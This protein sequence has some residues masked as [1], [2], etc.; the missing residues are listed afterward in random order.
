MKDASSHLTDGFLDLEVPLLLVGH[1]D[2]D[3]IVN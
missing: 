1:E 3:L 2:I